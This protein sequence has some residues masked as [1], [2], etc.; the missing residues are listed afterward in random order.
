MQTESTRGV[1]VSGW[2]TIPFPRACGPVWEVAQSRGWLPWSWE[3]CRFPSQ[4]G[5]FSMRQRGVCPGFGGSALEKEHES[6]WGGLPAS[7]A[8]AVGAGCQ[9]AAAAASTQSSAPAAPQPGA[10][11]RGLCRLHTEWYLYTLLPPLEGETSWL[12]W[13]PS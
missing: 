5:T 2:V 9:A 6:G 7:S 13:L 10:G 1:P 11:G 4:E 3:L 8:Q 12:A